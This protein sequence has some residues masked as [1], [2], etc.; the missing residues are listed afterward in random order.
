MREIKFDQPFRAVTRKTV[1]KETKQLETLTQEMLI[2]S[3]SGVIIHIKEMPGNPIHLWDAMPEEGITNASIDA[4]LKEV[5]E[6]I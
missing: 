1:R 3:E 2:I 5:L 4:R 6:D